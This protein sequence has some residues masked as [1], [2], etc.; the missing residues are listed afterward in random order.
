MI[1]IY[2]KCSHPGRQRRRVD[3]FLAGLATLSEALAG[4]RP[5]RLV[6]DLNATLPTSTSEASS[7]G[8]RSTSRPRLS[9]DLDA[10]LTRK[11]PFF[12]KA[13]IEGG[14]TLQLLDDKR[15][16]IGPL[17]TGLRQFFQVLGT[18]GH[19]RLRRRHQPRSREVRRERRLP[20]RPV[21]D[22]RRVRPA[23]RAA[24][25]AARKRRAAGRGQGASPTPP[26]LERRR[27]P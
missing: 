1:A 14:K 3:Q 16:P 17:I 4:A 13:V 2:A 20:A 25:I 27:R 18:I 5:S 22:V 15:E 8:R 26:R 9:A 12:D 21:R 11:R 6:D 24:Q 7:S 23:G 19:F 10:L